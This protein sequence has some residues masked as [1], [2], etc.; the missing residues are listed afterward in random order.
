[1]GSDL[2]RSSHCLMASEDPDHRPL[3]GVHENQFPFTLS[4]ASGRV[5]VVEA[6]TNL[7]D[8][9]SSPVSTNTLT[10][11]AAYFSDAEWTKYPA[12]FYR[13]RSP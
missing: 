10:D 9:I 3:F 6:C 12:R 2:C 4:W 1:M 8:P 11:G 5:V 7:A 13:I